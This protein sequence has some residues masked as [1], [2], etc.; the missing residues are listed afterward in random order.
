MYP[1]V[2][3][4]E[5]QSTTCEPSPD[6][7]QWSYEFI[8]PEGPQVGTIAIDGSSGVHYCEDPAVLIGDHFTLGVILP[9]VLTEP[10]DIV[11]VIDKSLNYFSE[12]KFLVMAVPGKDELEVAAFNTREEMP[13]G[14][15]VLGQVILSQIPWLPCMK[16]TRTGFMEVDEYF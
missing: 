8:D 4:A 5:L 13:V 2:T 14:A 12:R 1:G 7:G 3:K 16:P 10:V 9:D 6:P 11:M 15:E